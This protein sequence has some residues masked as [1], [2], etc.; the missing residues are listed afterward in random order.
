VRE[1]KQSRVPHLTDR[2]AVYESL[3]PA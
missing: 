1:W 2:C 3:C